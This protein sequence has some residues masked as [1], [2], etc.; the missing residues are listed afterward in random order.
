MLSNTTKNPNDSKVISKCSHCGMIYEA[1]YP[2][3]CS[4]NKK[5]LYHDFIFNRNR[6]PY[7]DVTYCGEI[8]PPREDIH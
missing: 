7:Y 1:D 4:C 3:I 2:I 8:I 5:D 6:Y